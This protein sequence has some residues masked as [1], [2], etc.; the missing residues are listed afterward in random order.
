METTEVKRV[1]V[2]FTAEEDRWLTLIMKQEPS[3]TAGK[4]H[5]LHQEQQAKRGE[6]QFP[7]RYDGAILVRHHSEVIKG[8]KRDHK[9]N[10]ARH[11]QSLVRRVRA[12]EL[13]EAEA[14]ALR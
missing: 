5:K 7:D 2:Q 6:G 12:G 11:I 3:I 9:T 13:T 1:P 4:L 14:M 10:K 8:D